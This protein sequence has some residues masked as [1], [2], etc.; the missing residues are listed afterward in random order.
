MQEVL[1][2][3]VRLLAQLVEQLARAVA[4]ASCDQLGGAGRAILG[5]R[6]RRH[7]LTFV[8]ARELDREPAGWKL[9]A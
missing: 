2:N 3:S 9:G 7:P 5:S 4:E 6:D 1:E 8:G